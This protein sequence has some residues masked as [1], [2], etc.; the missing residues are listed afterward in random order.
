MSDVQLKFLTPG[1]DRGLLVSAFGLPLAI[2]VWRRKDFASALDLPIG[3][4]YLM[5][6]I[7]L[8]LAMYVVPLIAFL[9]PI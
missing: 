8:T 1:I 2:M 3:C 4:M 9:L 5:L 6:A 7:G